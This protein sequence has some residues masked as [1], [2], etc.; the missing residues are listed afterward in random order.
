ML[1]SERQGGAASI[2]IS[3]RVYTFLMPRLMFRLL[4]SSGFGEGLNSSGFG[5]SLKSSGFGK[6]KQQWVWQKLKALPI[7]PI[8][9]VNA[10][11]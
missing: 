10:M 7:S 4:K 2:D 9:T 3:L 11:C 6:F 5:E 8:D 1:V